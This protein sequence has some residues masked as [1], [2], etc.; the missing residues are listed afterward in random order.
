M[1]WRKES[2]TNLQLSPEFALITAHAVHHPSDVFK[3]LPKFC[4]H[5]LEIK[6]K[7]K[8]A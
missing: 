8:I 4:L 1:G 3:M 7:Y 5:L 2:A 6:M